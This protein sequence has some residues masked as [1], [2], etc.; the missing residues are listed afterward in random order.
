MKNRYLFRAKCK[1]YDEPIWAIGYLQDLNNGKEPHTLCIRPLDGDFQY[2]KEIAL[3]AAEVVDVD[4]VGQCT[5]VKDKNGKLVFEGDIIKFGF[6]N[7]ILYGIVEWQTEYDPCFGINW[8]SYEYKDG[9]EKENEP[10]LPEDALCVWGYRSEI[11]GNIYDNSELL[12]EAT[13]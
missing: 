5:G 8:I 11:I 10:E 6:G 4:T 9:H 1:N 2:D 13:Q 3:G 7:A 12:K